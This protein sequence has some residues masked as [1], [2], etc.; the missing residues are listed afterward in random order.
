MGRLLAKTFLII[1][2]V[3]FILEA[4]M[5]F[6]C[7]NELCKYSAAMNGH[8]TTLSCQ[9][10]PGS[11]ERCPFFYILIIEATAFLL[12]VWGLV[13][14]F[15]MVAAVLLQIIFFFVISFVITRIYKKTHSKKQE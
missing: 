3:W 8:N 15:N 13:L 14:P 11:N 6:Q 4:L 1:I 10:Y 9:N 5:L 12:P 7:F 2:I